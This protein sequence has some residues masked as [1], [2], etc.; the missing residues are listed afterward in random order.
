MNKEGGQLIKNYTIRSTMREILEDL[1]KD[2]KIQCRHCPWGNKA[3][4][5]TPLRQ[6]WMGYYCSSVAFNE[7]GI[8]RHDK[9]KC[10]RLV[11]QIIAE[12]ILKDEKEILTRRKQ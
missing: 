1:C 5:D 7:E 10:T 3:F 6:K 9:V 11:T 4:Y 12:K 8:R 2:N